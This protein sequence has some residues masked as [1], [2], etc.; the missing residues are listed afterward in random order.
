MLEDCRMETQMTLLN[1]DLIDIHMRLALK[2]AFSPPPASRE[3]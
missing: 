3:A 2:I 1:R